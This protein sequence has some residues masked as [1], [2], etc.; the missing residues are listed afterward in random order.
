MGAGAKTFESSGKSMKDVI[1]AD[2]DWIKEKVTEIDPD[3][4]I[5]TLGNGEKVNTFQLFKFTKF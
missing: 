1:P 5:V 2:A 3:N 4:N